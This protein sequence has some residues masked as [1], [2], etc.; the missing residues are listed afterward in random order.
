MTTFLDWIPQISALVAPRD[1][2]TVFEAVPAARPTSPGP[3]KRV[4]LAEVNDT[5]RRFCAPDAP[6]I[7][8][9]IYRVRSD[10]IILFE[11]LWHGVVP[12]DQER[13]RHA[14]GAATFIR[15]AEGHLSLTGS[16]WTEELASKPQ[17]LSTMPVEITDVSL[18]TSPEGAKLMELS[19]A[20]LEALRCCPFSDDSSELEALLFLRWRYMSCFN[21]VVSI[22]RTLSDEPLRIAGRRV[23]RFR[24]FQPMW[25][26]ILVVALYQI[27][28]A[29]KHFS[30]EIIRDPAGHWAGQTRLDGEFITGVIDGLF[31]APVFYFAWA[32]WGRHRPISRALRRGRIYLHLGNALNEI[33]GRIRGQ[34]ER[35]A[36]FTIG[37]EM[38]MEIKVAEVRRIWVEAFFCALV[39]LVASRLSTVI[40]TK[41]E[42]NGIWQAP[43]LDEVISALLRVLENLLG[44]LP[45]AGA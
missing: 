23:L 28:N 37:V 32:Y 7:A 38:L 18:A 11:I 24:K 25:A 31:W 43:S 13:L 5:I 17:A 2:G 29:W 1:M 4:F 21:K 26:T 22:W 8:A 44:L 10:G 15:E 27:F 9:L 20:N 34:G 14:L 3:D 6:E 12:D 30:I 36:D 19:D 35:L 42:Q 40:H 33:V 41:F 39:A 45:G 16:S